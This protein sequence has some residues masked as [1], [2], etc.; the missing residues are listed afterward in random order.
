LRNSRKN[1]PDLCRLEAIFLYFM[2][3]I[4][5]TLVECLFDGTIQVLLISIHYINYNITVVLYTILHNT[6]LC[7]GR[8]CLWKKTYRTCRGN[9]CINCII[10]NITYIIIIRNHRC[11]ILYVYVRNTCTHC[12]AIIVTII[13]RPT[14]LRR[15]W[16][17]DNSTRAALAALKPPPPGVMKTHKHVVPTA[18]VGRTLLKVQLSGACCPLRPYPT[19]VPH[20]FSKFTSETRRPLLYSR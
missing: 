4:L 3:A 11:K 14:P 12:W 8:M 19:A 20:T 1:P 6:V 10:I 7:V 16:K 9:Q 5:R 2:M 18:T 15:G 17:F 13:Y